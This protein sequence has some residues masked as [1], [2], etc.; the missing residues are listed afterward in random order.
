MAD[1]T[2]HTVRDHGTIREAALWLIWRTVAL[3]LA[4]IRLVLALLCALAPSLVPLWQATRPALLRWAT[5]LP[6]RT[7]A[8]WPRLCAHYARRPAAPYVACLGAV[9]AFALLSGLV[10]R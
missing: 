2:R 4:L 7:R 9:V 1:T 3:P 10:S 8:A 5:E 6:G